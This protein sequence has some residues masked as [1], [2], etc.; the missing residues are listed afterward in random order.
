MQAAAAAQ[1]S[2]KRPAPR[3][4]TTMPVPSGSFSRLRTG[5]GFRMSNAR[6][7]IKPA[8]SACH[9]MG[10]AIKRDQLPGDFVDHHMRGIF[11]AAAAGFQGCRRNADRHDQDDQYQDGGNSCR[12]P[13][14]AKPAATKAAQSPALPRCQARDEAGRRRRTSRPAW[15][16]RGA[17]LLPAWLSLAFC[18]V[19][20]GS[21]NR[22]SPDRSMARR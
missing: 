12:R 8:S 19:G 4:S 13:E 14:G 15:P 5:G 20:Q 9:T 22:R 6:K 18:I 21:W 11:P 10:H 7:S 3:S 2:R 17:E 16:S 1:S